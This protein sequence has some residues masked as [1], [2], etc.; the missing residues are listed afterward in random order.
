MVFT[1][2]L[3]SAHPS[4]VIVPDSAAGQRLDVFLTPH[5]PDAGRTLV[6][7]HINSGKVLLNGKP[8]KSSQKLR[9]GESIEV[10]EVEEV[11]LGY[12]SGDGIRVRIKV[13]GSMD[14]Q[15]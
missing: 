12:L 1:D 7:T 15:A 3:V 6:Q 14:L 8:A 4:P 13:A 5:F 9:G 10:L 11:P 2:M